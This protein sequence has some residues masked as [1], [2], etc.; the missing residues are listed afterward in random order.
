MSL[1]L[2]MRQVLF[3]GTLLAVPLVAYFMVFKPRNAEIGLANAEIADKRK[4]LENLEK[5]RK[6]IS[7]FETA[8]D[9]SQQAISDIEAKLPTE[10]GVDEVLRQTSEIAATH[11]L[12]VT[13]VQP[14]AKVPASRYMELP[15]NFELTGNFDGFY[16][17]LLDLEDL[18]RL[19]RLK[20]L[21]MERAEDDA[22][23]KMTAAFTLSVYFMP[24]AAGNTTT[25]V[26]G[27]D[28]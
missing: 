13:L 3:V 18:Q 14:Q 11:G 12:A 21:T 4:T 15:I 28:S 25:K 23:G 16:E 10:Q 1:K 7:D 19:I 6:R 8:I 9:Q 2:G 24:S 26:A 20:N 17:F 5:V 27:A 22:D